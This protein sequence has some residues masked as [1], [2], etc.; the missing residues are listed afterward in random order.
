MR[1]DWDHGGFVSEYIMLSMDGAPA[2]FI[3]QLFFVT[4]GNYMLYFDSM[5]FNEISILE[6]KGMLQYSR[7]VSHRYEPWCVTME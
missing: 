4:E 5:C 1:G 3:T 7:T 2:C 6:Q